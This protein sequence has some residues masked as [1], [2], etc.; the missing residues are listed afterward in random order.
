MKKR[1]FEIAKR[2]AEH[3]DYSQHKMG[4]VITRGNKIISIGFN[5]HKTHPKSTNKYNKATHAEFSA[6][7]KARESLEGASI[8]IYRET[9]NG[10][11]GM[12]RPCP[13]CQKLLLACGIKT[14]YYSIDNDYKEEH[15]IL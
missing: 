1:F 8:Y 9:R 4:A 2:A 5:A 11:K 6:I 15:V 7:L 12:A 14:W 10:V 3:S 13:G